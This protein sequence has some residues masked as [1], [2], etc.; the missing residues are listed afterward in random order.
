V[1]HLVD[2]ANATKKRRFGIV[3]LIVVVAVVMTIVL[4]PQTEYLPNGNQNFLFCFV[5][6]PPGYNLDE[7]VKIGQNLEGQLTHL[8]ETSPEESNHLPGGGIDNFFFVALPSQAFYGM[9]AHDPAVY[10]N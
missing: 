2:R 10:G 8:W 7:V 6:P 5:L 4:M 1:A 3:A 9:T